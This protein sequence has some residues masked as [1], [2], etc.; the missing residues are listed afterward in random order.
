MILDGRCMCSGACDILSMLPQLTIYF[1]YADVR[2]SIFVLLL[3]C[4]VRITFYF[5]QFVTLL[6]LGTASFLSIHIMVH[7]W[8]KIIED[9]ASWVI[10]FTIFFT[11]LVWW[12]LIVTLVPA[13]MVELCSRRF[14][15]AC[16]R[17][18]LY[19]FPKGDLLVEGGSGL[20]R[21]VHIDI[22]NVP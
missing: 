7:F 18:G 4:D 1:F 15:H 10:R 12:L 16:E 21:I 5:L 3:K 11:R 20:Y 2:L 19:Y 6:R 8:L 17:V 14:L 13:N 22:I 9:F